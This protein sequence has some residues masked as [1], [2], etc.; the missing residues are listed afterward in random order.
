MFVPCIMEDLDFMAL[1]FAVATSVFILG[2][3]IRVCGI[4]PLAEQ[5]QVCFNVCM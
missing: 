1:A 4:W 3:Y 5:I 2:E